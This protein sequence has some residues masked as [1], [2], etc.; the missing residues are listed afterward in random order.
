MNVSKAEE[1]FE[2]IKEMQRSCYKNGDR[3]IG[4]GELL[5][6]LLMDMTQ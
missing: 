4:G 3:I 5:I 2:Q 1:T 6:V